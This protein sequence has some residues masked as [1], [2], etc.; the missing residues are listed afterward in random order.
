MSKFRGILFITVVLAL[1][2][3]M[4]AMGATKVNLRAN[5]GPMVQAAE[6]TSA[7][8]VFGTLLANMPAADIRCAISVSNVLAMPDKLDNPGGYVTG[9]ADTTGTLEFYLWNQDGTPIVY[10]TSADTVANA[11]GAGLNADGT[12]GP[13]MTY[14]VGLDEILTDAG[15][16]DVDFVGYGWVIANFDGVQGTYNNTIYTLNFTQAYTFEPSIGMSQLFGSNG[17]F[18][19]PLSALTLP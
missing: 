3:G 17:G 7:V 2:M 12:L 18:P 14:S 10:E 1:V 19:V 4:S 5:S 11:V 16:G 9:S 8:A 13:G 6:T 15:V